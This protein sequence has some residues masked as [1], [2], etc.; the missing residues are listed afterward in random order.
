MSS[1]NTVEK[2]LGRDNQIGIDIWHRKYQK[3]GE[4][5]EE[6]LDRI[7]GGDDRLRELIRSK[8]FLFG[9]RILANRGRADIKDYKISLSNCYVLTVDDSI[10][11]IFDTSK[12]IARTLSVGGGVGV[13]L[14]ALAPRGARIRNAAETTT[15][16]VPFMDIYSSIVGSIGAEGRR[17]ALMI[18]LSCDHPDIE[19]FID[20]KTDLGR[21]EF[22]NISV[23]ATD[24]FMEAAKYDEDFKL[25]YTRAETGEVI[26][27]TINAGDLLYRLA[28]NNWNYAEPG[29]LFWD[30][31]ERW[32]LLSE[33]ADFR[34]A[35]I[36][37]C[38]TG[39]MR[40]LTDTGYKS[41]KEL[42]GT[43]VRILNISGDVS[44]SSVWCSGRKEIVSLNFSDKRKIK[45]TPDHIF[46]TVEGN[47][48]AAKDMAGQTPMPASC[49]IR[50][51]DKEYIKLGFIQGDGQL[52]R[53]KSDHFMALDVNIGERDSDIFDLFSDEDYTIK[54][55]RAIYLSGFREKLLSLQF[56]NECLPYRCFPLTYNTWTLDQKASFLQGMYSANGCVIKGHR[57]GY[58]TTC[59][60]LSEQLVSALSEFG[61]EA[62]ITTNK[63]K[64]VV[65]PNGEYTCR[66]SY[67]VNIS[68]YWD[69]QTFNLMINFYQQYK[70]H[71]LKNLLL[72]KAPK[73]VSVCE[74]GEEL[75]Y[76]F[77]EEVS[78]WGYV[79]GVAVH[80]CGE[81]PL[82]AGGACLL[83]AINLSEYVLYPFTE[84]AQFEFAR[85]HTD[86]HTYIKAL[87]DV[88][89]EG[90]PL[91]PLEE[92]RESA[93]KWRQ[94][95]LGVMGLAD[96]FLKLGLGYGSDEAVELCGRIMNSIAYGAIHESAVLAKEHGAYPGYDG[97]AMQTAYFECVT[98]DKQ[99]S[100]YEILT[101]MIEKTGLRNSQ[102]LV[103]APT[104]TI[105]T[106]LGVSGGAEPIFANSYTRLT[107]SLH[108]VDTTYKV[109]HPTVKEYMELYDISD[110]SMLP[111]YFVTAHDIDPIYRIAIQAELQRYIDASIS[112]TINLPESATIEDI[113]D[114]YIIAYEY[115][116]KGITVFREGCARLPV[117]S[118]GTEEDF[119][120]ADTESGGM[121]RGDVISVSDNVIG[122]KRRLTT[123]CGTLHCTAFFD[124]ISGDLLETYLSKGS[125]GGCNNSLTGLS[126]M[127]SIAARGG[128]SIHGIVDQ[129]Q[130]SGVCPSYAVRKATK[131]DTS[132]G[133]SCPVAVANALADMH[134]S[135]QTVMKRTIDEAM[136]AEPEADDVD[137]K[138]DGTKCPEC[139]EPIIF[140]NGCSLCRACGWSRCN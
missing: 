125:T 110:E 102:L 26:E 134:A 98:E 108:G 106:M 91:H 15:G 34:Y 82:P 61:I 30:G 100:S 79:E 29:M 120:N 139:N 37:P 9:G 67:D 83:G 128:V 6:W 104:G 97:T 121:L 63:S 119:A 58:K 53:L 95:G 12:K 65:F 75:V 113:K 55:H 5:F 32:N 85:L 69:I 28:E 71:Q 78:H 45:C 66:E 131:N 21:V 90:I 40:I 48:F 24:A 38:F 8:K 14:S 64:N 112:S 59:K 70:R 10:E 23:R 7:S 89:D 25:S 52:S 96:M 1:I 107:K 60:V 76:D 42:E 93:E 57:I 22:A 101:D 137:V 103:I 68:K 129:L 19:E 105:S 2:W 51:N 13:D 117:L 126:R 122:L 80:N 86:V 72:H 138:D 74:E 62:Y 31:I 20:V 36:N 124:P 84:D 43:E 47:E 130:S 27:K 18:S 133:S 118:T 127:I 81:E 111:D 46:M 109:F 99:Y 135:I 4:T 17:G 88:L 140:E 16:V 116:L 56:S 49:S 11:S 54:S 3:N 39:D 115:G 50:K 94:I 33:N 123:G 92:Q 136:M 77:S 73:I 41:F 87:N 44:K 35:G 114:I 132:K